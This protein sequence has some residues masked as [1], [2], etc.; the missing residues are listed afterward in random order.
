M[1]ATSIT[2]N[3]SSIIY[4]IDG[5]KVAHVFITGTWDGASVAVET[6]NG[7]SSWVQHPL[8]GLKN[9]SFSETYAI[10]EQG[11]LRL[12]ATSCGASTDL[13]GQVSEYRP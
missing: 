9:A 13:W 11:G 12:T 10:P 8:N 7:N 2:S 5:G 3:G 4:G 1:A 6:R